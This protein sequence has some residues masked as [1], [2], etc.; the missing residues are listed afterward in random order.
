LRLVPTDLEIG[1]SEGFAPGRDIFGRKPFGE[2]LIRMVTALEGPAVLLLDAPWGTGKTTFVKMWAGELRKERIASVYFDAFANDY[3]EDAFLAVAS[4]IIAL[5]KNLQPSRTDAIESFTTKAVQVARIFARASIRLG[6]RAA[7]AGLIEGED[8]EK[9][10]SEIAESGKEEAQKAI[11]GLL[12]KRLESHEADRTSFEEFKNALTKLAE[13]LSGV[14]NGEE[15]SIGSAEKKSK[16]PFVFII[17]ELDRCRPSFALEILEKIKHLFSV[18]GVVFFLVG[19]LSQLE[20]IVKSSYGDIDTRSYLEKFYHLRILFPSGR[21]GRPD[22]GVATYLRHLE[23]NDN[24]SQLIAQFAVVHPLSFRT[25]ERIVSY[26]TVVSISMVTNS[27]FIPH[28]I[29][30]LCILK[31]IEPDL[32]AATRRGT[33]TFDTLQAHLRFAEWRHPNDVERRLSQ[34]KRAE[35]WWR[36]ALI[37]LEEGEVKQNLERGLAAHPQLLP[38]DIIPYYCDMIDGFEFPSIPRE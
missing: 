12:Q 27:V 26:A 8:W 16:L 32:Y 37:E 20:M 24:I 38:S 9:I 6:L 31:V 1:P 35:E 3:Q 11:D 15:D 29:A 30:P 10:G 17:D 14:E 7:T 4:Q 22:L 13:K 25:L 21:P 33:A 34:G 2:R 18:P 28:I 5:A 36:F 23:V 19:S